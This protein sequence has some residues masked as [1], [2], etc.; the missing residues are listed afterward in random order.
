MFYKLRE[1]EYCTSTAAR[2]KNPATSHSDSYI[3]RTKYLLVHCIW[4]QETHW[5]QLLILPHLPD[6][7]EQEWLHVGGE[8]G[9]LTPLVRWWE[10][11]FSLHGRNGQQ[12]AGMHRLHAATGQNPS[13]TSSTVMQKKNGTEWGAI[14][15]ERASAPILSPIFLLVKSSG[16]CF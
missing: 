8:E 12:G 6:A 7:G 16:Y 11:V 1:D 5:S 14:H 3:I 9:I 13:L 15:K 4:K 10:D 2:P